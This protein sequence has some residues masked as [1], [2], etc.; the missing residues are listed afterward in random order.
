MS[1]T[2]AKGFVAAG[3][4]CGIKDGDV[5]DLSL[6]AT[7]GA[8]P[9]VAAAVFTRNKMTAAPV[10]VSRR[11]LELTRNEATAV[12]LNSGNAN[13]GT[14]EV[15]IGDADQ[16]C[17]LTAAALGCEPQHVLVCSTGLIGNR[18]PMDVITP[19]IP[20]VAGELAATGGPLAAEAIRTTDTHRK[21]SVAKADGVV[22]GGMAKGSAMLRPDMAT[23]LAV[24]T[25]DADVT[26][27]ELQSA[28]TGAVDDSFN[29][30][31]TDGA[32]STNDTVM[33]LASGKAGRP[34]LD[35]FAA[36]LHEVCVDLATQM[37]ND[38]EGAT[39]VV[40]ITV[41]GAASDAEATRGARAVA[42]CQLIKCSWAGNDPY[43]GRIASELGASGIEFEQ[44]QVSV[45]YGEFEV[46]RGGVDAAHDAGGLASYMQQR[47]IDITADLGVGDG[48]G[49]VLTVDLT[50]GYVDENMG[51]S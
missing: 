43:W 49:H 27:A 48:T 39:K 41:T 16:M 24:I 10:Q 30:L 47:F 44:S 34:D 42:E 35:T 50:H 28:L 23:M 3:I 19:G 25:T 8:V 6:V 29:R 40:R 46:A 2:A 20:L 11:H 12:I 22:V 32:Q 17:R 45:S 38:A 15:G 33:V 26:A 7:A 5:P 18:L 51:T 37:A 9:V 13:A 4:H 31:T 21:E 36:Q 1:V 14:G